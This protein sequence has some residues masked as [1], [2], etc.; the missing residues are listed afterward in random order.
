MAGGLLCSC[1][2]LLHAVQLVHGVQ[3]RVYPGRVHPRTRYTSVLGLLS[4]DYGIPR[5]RY[6]VPRTQY[7]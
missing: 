2:P 4:S 6:S 5:P 3:C 1:R 7:T